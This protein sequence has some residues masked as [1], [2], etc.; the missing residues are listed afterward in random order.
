[1]NEK[2]NVG[3]LYVIAHPFSEIPWGGHVYTS[4]ESAEIDLNKEK[5]HK[6]LLK[7][8]KMRDFLWQLQHGK[9]SPRDT[10]FYLKN[11]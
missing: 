10:D 8:L 4:F 11:Q 7:V 6:K 2:V 5:E 1:M 9:P 3:N